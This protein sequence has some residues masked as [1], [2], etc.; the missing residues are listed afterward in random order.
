M[1]L[2]SATLLWAALQ[3]PAAPLG[4][5]GLQGWVRQEGTRQPLPG[6]RLE[7]VHQGVPIQHAYADRRGFYRLTSVPAGWQTVRAWHPGHDTLEL[8][9]WVP[10]GADVTVEFALAARPV[11]LAPLDV[12]ARPSPLE[13]DSASGP[14]LVG[15]GMG[16][17]GQKALE[18]GPGVD[19]VTPAAGGAP[20]PQ[21]GAE[22]AQPGDLL[23]VRSSSS[24][25][26]LVLLD[27]APVYAPF[28]LGGLLD[29]LDP[30]LLRSA[31]LYL[32]GAPARYGG[33]LSYVVELATRPGRGDR[34]RTDGAVDPL[35][36]RIVVEDAFGP[37]HWLVGARTV[38][39]IG[40]PLLGAGVFPY[41]YGEVV[42]RADIPRGPALLSATA[43]LNHEAVRLDPD[44]GL[45]AVWDNAAA[46]IRYRTWIGDAD[47]EFTLAAG[48]FGAAL[49]RGLEVVARGQTGR[50]RLAADFARLLGPTTLRYGAIV[51]RL[52]LD[53]EVTNDMGEPVRRRVVTDAAGA[54]AEVA[55][56]PVSVVRLRGGLRGDVF[57]SDVVSHLAP[58]LAVTLRLTEHASL[59]LAAGR[60]Y[61]YVRAGDFVHGADAPLPDPDSTP[62]ARLAVGR[63]SHWTV[64]LVQDV[65]PLGLQFG[66][67]GYYKAFGG[68][69]TLGSDRAFA[70]GM[71]LWLR[72]TGPVQSWI[73][74]SLG[75]VWADSLRFQGR[76]LLSAGAR[77]SVRDWVDVGVRFAY[78]AGLPFSALPLPNREDAVAPPLGAPLFARA[79]ADQIPDRPPRTADPYVRLDLELSRTFVVGSPDGTMALTPYLRVLNAVGHRDALFYRYRRG[80][81]PERLATLP[82]LPLLGLEWR[83]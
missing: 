79:D 49:P 33:A 40:A 60:Y 75:W 61:Q 44:D 36:A 34:L 21:V 35:T 2:L 3:P 77:S 38:H 83:F 41:R 7:I 59:T 31:V 47:A 32:G 12:S 13:L 50:V 76:Q 82:L 55:W 42:A 6:A 18:E 15:P 54:Y 22:P 51:E 46:S 1:R 71:D 11:A 80:R 26:K 10:A 53:Q 48:R 29:P 56:A 65:Q 39:G 17:L 69:P 63:A 5:G 14:H 9:V 16:R 70:S 57:L 52:E 20:P 25:L 78:G 64:T 81:G 68:V 66:A 4:W 19:G 45:Q 74:Y 67:E 58:R 30:A 72:A 43:F 23:L 37:A 62:D 8:Q 24:D 28:H 73:G 27:G